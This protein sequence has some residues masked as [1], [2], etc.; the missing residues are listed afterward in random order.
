MPG[1]RIEHQFE[2]TGDG[3]A[4]VSAEGALA[5]I[6]PQAA[7]A[8][9]DP[10]EAGA[11]LDQLGIGL[12]SLIPRGQA[13][14]VPDSVIGTV[15]IEVEGETATLYFLPEQ[16]DRQAYGLEIAAPMANAIQQIE[17]ISKRLL[18]EG[19]EAGDE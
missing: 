4:A 17:E 8:E 13:R 15:T 11:L 10:S 3:Y 6:A 16:E 5:G 18:E 12:D 2:L 14:F 1:E 19:K 9:L 7:S